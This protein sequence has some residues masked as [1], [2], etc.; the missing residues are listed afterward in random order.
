MSAGPAGD[1][2]PLIAVERDTSV[3]RPG[4][5]ATLWRTFDAEFMQPIFGGPGGHQRV[6]HGSS[7]ALT[8]LPEALAGGQQL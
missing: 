8:E 7:D 4:S 3:D 2:A 6:D 5:I 1:A